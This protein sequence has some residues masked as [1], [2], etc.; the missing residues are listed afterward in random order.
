MR[1]PKAL[2]E[3]VW[4]VHSGR[5]FDAKCTV[6]WCE[7]VITVFDFEVGHNIPR[8]KGGADTIDNLRPLCSKCNKSMSDTYTIDEFSALSVRAHTAWDKFRYTNEEP[9]SPPHSSAHLL[10]RVPRA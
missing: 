10:R 6:R 4:I 2:R 9:P 1:L 8:S 3:Q 5:T 7:N